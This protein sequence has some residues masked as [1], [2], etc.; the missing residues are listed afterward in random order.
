[1]ARQSMIITMAVALLLA[2]ATSRA[3]EAEGK[4][5]LQHFV[6][7]WQSEVTNKPAKWHP[8]GGKH[9]DREYTTP[10]LKGQF[11]LGRQVA[12]PGNVKS[13]WLLTYKPKSQDYLFW[14]FNSEGVLGGEWSGTWDKASQT[15]TGHAADTPAG[16]TSHVSDHFPD[17]KSVKVAIWMKDESGTLLMDARATKR[18]QPDDAGKKTL[19]AWA[20]NHK[21]DAPVSDELKVLNRMIGKWDTVAVSKQAEWTPQEIRTTGR[22]IS[23]WTLNRSLVMVNTRNSDGT[24]GITLSAYD[25]QKKAFRSWWFGSEGY[26]NKSMGKW[27]ELTETLT[28]HAVLDD[29]LSMRTATRFIN[30]DHHDVRVVITDDKGKLY[31]DC[32]W[33]ITR[34]KK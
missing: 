12:K 25:S 18:R 4:K 30:K 10:V 28:S 14:F 24:Q 20:T 6:G 7:S 34:R 11:I 23:T 15:W 31:F 26:F 22:T 16:W 2:T 27:D 32:K 5:V 3:A 19:T 8:D 29:G 9:T 33:D 21:P 17:N 13:L 1:M